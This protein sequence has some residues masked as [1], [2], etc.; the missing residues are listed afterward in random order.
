MNA[1]IDRPPATG[2]TP[3]TAALARP[4]GEKGYRGFHQA[5]NGRCEL[6]L[7]E[8]LDTPAGGPA[9]ERAADALALAGRIVATHGMPARHA[10]TRQQL[11]AFLGVYDRFFRL[12]A[13]WELDAVAPL[14]APLTWRSAAGAVLVDVVRT[15]PPSHP[16]ADAD[17]FARISQAT[18]WAERCGLRLAG[19]RLLALSA[20]ATSLLH[21]PVGGLVPLAGTRYAGALVTPAGVAA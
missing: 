14:E 7:A 4:A 15:A 12:P 9:W 13:G 5:L 16:L 3:A 18:A 2:P 6:A 21:D 11:A 10:A 19:V 17:S 8:H 1:V 20:P